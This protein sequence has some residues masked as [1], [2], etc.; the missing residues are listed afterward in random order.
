MLGISIFLRV[1]NEVFHTFWTFGRGIDEVHNGYP[2][3][4]L[5]VLGRHEEWE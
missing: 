4:D 1:D 5:T 3:L 2:W